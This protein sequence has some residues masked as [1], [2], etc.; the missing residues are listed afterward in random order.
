M[1]QACNHQVSARRLL[2]AAHSLSAEDE[3]E[4]LKLLKYALMDDLLTGRVRITPLLTAE[5]SQASA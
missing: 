1:L 5:H 3:F 2:W 4:Q